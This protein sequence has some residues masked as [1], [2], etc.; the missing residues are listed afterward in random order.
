MVVRASFYLELCMCGPARGACARARTPLPTEYSPAAGS[1]QQQG[2]R[3]RTFCVLEADTIVDGNV[4]K[5]N[6]YY[7][8]FFHFIPSSWLTK[9]NL[10]FNM[11]KIKVHHYDDVSG[12]KMAIGQKVYEKCTFIELLRKHHVSTAYIYFFFGIIY[13]LLFSIYPSPFNIYNI[14]VMQSA[15]RELLLFL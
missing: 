7:F 12:K 3:A 5:N 13:T 8:C 4:N 6:C 15:A 2:E 9:K 1:R 10:H 11:N 14:S